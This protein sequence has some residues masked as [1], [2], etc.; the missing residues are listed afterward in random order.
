MNRNNV[1]VMGKTIPT[2][3]MYLTLFGYAGLQK[4]MNFSATSTHF[5]TLFKDTFVPSLPG[6]M[7]LQVGFIAG[8]EVLIAL[9][10]LVSLIRKEFLPGACRVWI[11]LGLILSSL[12]FIHLGI[13]QRLIGDYPSAATTFFYFGFTQVLLYLACEPSK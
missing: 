1:M 5:S 9:M 4:F 8:V 7:G 13:G 11:I 3:L 10:F 2:Q 12:L 6:G